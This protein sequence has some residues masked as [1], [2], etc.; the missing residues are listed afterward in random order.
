MYEDEYSSWYSTASTPVEPAP[1]REHNYAE[2]YWSAE[3]EKSKRRSRR[4]TFWLIAS[5]VAL[6]IIATAWIF[7]GRKPAPATPEMEGG[8]LL[9]EL[10]QPQKDADV[11]S[12]PAAET[13]T[14]VTMT[15][16]GKPEGETLS[17]QEIY[18]K[19]L[20]SVV[21]IRTNYAEAV[22]Y[23][24]GTGIIMTEDG[25]IIT[26]AHV[27][28]GGK[29]VQVTLLQDD[30]EYEAKL[31]GT[32]SV[33]DIAVLK[34]DAEGLTPAEFGDSSTLVVGDPVSAIG[35]PLQEQLYG[36]MTVGIISAIN[37]NV[38]YDG[39]SMTLLQT[40]TAINEGNSG[41]P[42]INAWGQ[43]IGV[44]NMKAFTTGVEGICFAIPTSVVRP[45]VDA[46]IAEGQVK[47]RPSI[48]IT[49]GPLSESAKEY[50]DLPSGLYIDS[51]AEGSDAEAKGV[52]SGD[53]LTAV[54]GET[55]TTTY[56]V[57]AIK[58]RYAVGDTLTLT[59]YRDGKTFDVEVT[60]V[61]TNDIY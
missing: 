23:A 36:T 13:G 28:D 48:G 51:V 61:D 59:L 43:V 16:T 50:Y 34:I 41:G 42:L 31:V 30:S 37:R 55:V 24:L 1:E 7:G 44:T 39:H 57:N 2:A 8:Q 33:S 29:S 52:Q 4:L 32:D 46:L 15:I 40:D 25:Y 49:V 56:E 21:A 45:V 38:I 9:P 58:E 53:V 11:A 6:L 19:C 20:P 54:N 60:L 22:G 5:V 18:A 14:G 17:Y 12:I 47:G 3:A 26:N 35:N 27:L 10:E